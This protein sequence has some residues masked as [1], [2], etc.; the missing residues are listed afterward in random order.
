M[1]GS[2]FLSFIL[3]K[4]QGPAH[5]HCE[6]WP[7]ASMGEINTVFGW[8]WL[9]DLPDVCLTVVPHHWLTLSIIDL[10]FLTDQ[11]QRVHANTAEYHVSASET[12][13]KIINSENWLTA[14]FILMRKMSFFFFSSG[15]PHWGQ[16]EPHWE[17]RGHMSITSKQWSVRFWA[18]MFVKTCIWWLHLIIQHLEYIYIMI[19][20]FFYNNVR[21]YECL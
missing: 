16:I 6:S 2:H 11:V 12:S 13:E 5:Y 19:L 14:L 3:Q 18:E 10:K 15:A 4:Q 9:P 1:T 20:K 17:V 7:L 8:M 21:T